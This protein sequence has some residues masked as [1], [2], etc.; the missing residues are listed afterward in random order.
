M[1]STTSLTYTGINKHEDQDI[2]IYDTVLK[3]ADY[4]QVFEN[5]A[6]GG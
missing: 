6:E 2:G 3:A 5:V 1:P 4:S